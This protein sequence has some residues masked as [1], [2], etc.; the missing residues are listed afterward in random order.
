MQQV[1]AGQTGPSQ[2]QDYSQPIP[3]GPG[4]GWGPTQIVSGFLAASASFAHDHRVAREYLA[5]P[6]LQNWQPGWAVTVV[7]KAP[8]TSPLPIIPKTFASQSQ[9]YARVKVTGLPVATLTG[10]GQYQAF[11]GS[12]SESYIFSLTKINDQWRIDELPTSQLL[13][14]QADFQRV[15]QPRN[16]YFLAQSD[17]ILVPDPVFVPAQAT[18]TELATGLVTALLQDP[19]R[20]WLSGAAAT[21]FPPNSSLVGQVSVNGPN[22]TVDLG[23]KAAA[24]DQQQL[25]RMAAQLVWTLATGQTAIQS[26]ELELGGRPLQIM[27]SQYQLP[28]AYHGWVPM[29]TAGSGLYFIGSDGT[30]QALSGV[31]QTG[32][33][34]SGQVSAVPGA[35]GAAGVPPLSSIAVSADKRWVAGMTAGGGAVYIGGLSHGAALRQ[36]QPPDGS[37][38]SVSWDAQDDLWIACGGGVW[39]LPPGGGSASVVSLPSLLSGGQV[40]DFQVAPDGVRVVMIVRGTSRTQVQLAAVSRSGQSASVG[41]PVTIGAGIADPQSLSWYGTDDVIVLAGGTPGAQ[42]D[43]VP[44][45][46]G[47]PVTITTTGD[48]VSVAATSPAGSAASLA[49]GLSSGKIMVSTNLGAFQ[50]TRATGQAPVYPG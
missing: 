26:V 14:T 29:Q 37:C 48:P 43:E 38:T 5:A 46:G 18:N 44:L 3:A 49:V 1:G 31:G 12:A 30:V 13:L 2:E 19:R 32:P 45:N 20:G 41:Q 36:W 27:G 10:T 40:T 15:Y 33:G 11:S 34:Q 4:P 9:Q 35:A 16:L 7:S 23:G 25:T 50:P 6:A 21:A 42:L 17:Q 8:T 22:A 24:A 39:M 47:Q 28:Q